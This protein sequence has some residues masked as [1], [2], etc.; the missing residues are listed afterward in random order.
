LPSQAALGSDIH[1][2]AQLSATSNFVFADNRKGWHADAQRNELCPVRDSH[3][4][5]TNGLIKQDHYVTG[6]ELGVE[7]QQGSGTMTINS[8]DWG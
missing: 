2:T 6:F 8:F 5:I 3:Y 4:G 1:F 7:A